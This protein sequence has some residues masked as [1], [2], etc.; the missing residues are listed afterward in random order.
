[1]NENI[2]TRQLMKDRVKQ[3]RCAFPLVPPVNAC[4]VRLISFLLAYTLSGK[5]ATV[6]YPPKN[7]WTPGLLR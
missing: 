5:A 6:D 3:Q 7:P 2:P 1:M 4:L